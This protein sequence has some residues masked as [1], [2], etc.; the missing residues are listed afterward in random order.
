MNDEVKSLERSLW[1]IN[2]EIRQWLKKGKSGYT[3]TE[4]EKRT[5]KTLIARRD[6]TALE[7]KKRKSIPAKEK[8]NWAGA[9][10]STPDEPRK[11]STSGVGMYGVGPTS[12]FWSS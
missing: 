3:A 12:K 5:V 11:S 1:V 9:S 8:L 6:A 2:C 10:S 4:L 7:L